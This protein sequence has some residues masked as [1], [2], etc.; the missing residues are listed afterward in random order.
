MIRKVNHLWNSIKRVMDQSEQIVGMNS[1]NLSL[2]Y[3]NNHRRDYPLADNKLLTK[4]WLD[5]HH[6][7]TTNLVATVDHF[8]Q[9]DSTILA[10]DSS[11]EYVIKPAEGS[12]GKGILLAFKHPL[13]NQTWLDSRG[14]LLPHDALKGHIAQI[15]KGQFSHEAQSEV[16]LIETLVRPSKAFLPKLNQLCDLRIISLK[17]IVIA[18]MLRVPTKHSNG[19]ANL[20]Q[21]GIGLGVNLNN[22]LTHFATQLGKSISHHPD[23]L[24]A[25]EGIVI[26]D[27]Q[28][29]LKESTRLS[30]LCPLKYL[31]IDWALSEDGP[32]ILEINTRPGLE[33]QNANQEGLHQLIKDA[34]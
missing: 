18:G 2:I 20:H 11:K 4:Q 7:P 33:I 22:G 17:N 5:Q 32:K 24:E 19:K 21:G 14:A 27:W 10:L 12:G 9:I 31:G 3:P 30:E 25:L 1:R 8:T 23:T 34:Q 13:D 26:P 6:L 15:L 29:I 28:L 16:A